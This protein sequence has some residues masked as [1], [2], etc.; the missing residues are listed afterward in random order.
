MNALSQPKAVKPAKFSRE[1]DAKHCRFK[2]RISK[3]SRAMVEESEDPDAFIYKVPPLS[4]REGRCCTLLL[5]WSSLTT[6]LAVPPCAARCR[7]KQSN[8]LTHATLSDVEPKKRTTRVWTRRSAQGVMFLS[9][10]LKFTPKRR[11][12]NVAICST[13]PRSHG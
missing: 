1:S 6:G 11:N 12:V 3:A 10:T 8:L 5:S 13:V 9:H 4:L 2:P 7:R